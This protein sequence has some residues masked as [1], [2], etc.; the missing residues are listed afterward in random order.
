MPSS[1]ASQDGTS[2]AATGSVTAEKTTGMPE[3]A[4]AFLAIC[5]TGV[6]IV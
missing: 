6:V 4:S 3:P 1:P 5:E 2:F